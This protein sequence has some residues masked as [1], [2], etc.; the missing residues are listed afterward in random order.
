MASGLLGLLAQSCYGRHSAARMWSWFAQMGVLVARDR[1][2]AQRP[3]I[4]VTM[5]LLVFRGIVPFP[6]LSCLVV[7]S[8]RFWVMARFIAIVVKLSLTLMVSTLL[9][10]SVHRFRWGGGLCMARARE[11]A[12]LTVR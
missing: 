5:C 7:V 10:V 2:V 8:S 1:W 12:S 11:G 9:L 6:W 3:R 4:C